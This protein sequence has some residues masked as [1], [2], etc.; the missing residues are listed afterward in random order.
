MA[1]P[2]RHIWI[3]RH[4]PKL[5]ELLIFSN[6][7]V[8]S[9]LRYAIVTMTR[10]FVFI[11]GLFVSLSFLKFDLAKVGWLVAAIS[12]G[13]G[14]GLQEIV[15]NFVSGI[16]LLVERPIRVGDLITVG[17]SFGK[18]TRI[19]IRS[20]T[21]LTP[22]LQ[23]L[24]IP[25]RDLITKEVINWT[26]GNANIRILVNIGVAYGS[27][28]DKVM[29]ILFNLAQAQP[30]CL[31]NPQPEV[32]FINHGASSLDFELRLFLPNPSLR[33]PILSRMNCLINKA[34]AE[35]GIEIPFPQQDIH[36]RS[37][38]S[39]LLQPVKKNY[40]HIVR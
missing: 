10:Y 28:V 23:E 30:E 13:L 32:L 1:Q 20:T 17:T 29:K 6:I 7:K 31:K 5:F 14:F 38:L 25:N 37:G 12:V 34:F 4:L 39:S 9:G 2:K 16:I 19:N 27:D 15:A 21:I 35:N 18:V 33:W 36:L 26:L 40:N 24:L 3:V 22:D 8:D 11:V